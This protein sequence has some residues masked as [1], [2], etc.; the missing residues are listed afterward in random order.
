[1]E[2]ALAAE[3]ATE[4]DKEEQKK[5][6]ERAKVD[7]LTQLSRQGSVLEKKRL[8]SQKAVGSF[9]RAI[10]DLMFDIPIG[11]DLEDDLSTDGDGKPRKRAPSRTDSKAKPPLEKRRSDISGLI[12]KRLSFGSPESGSKSEPHVRH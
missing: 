4:V 9:L 2:E 3:R 11:D 6:E 12:N 8:A 10:D 5:A 7:R 1:M